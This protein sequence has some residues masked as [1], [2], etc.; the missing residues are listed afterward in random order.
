MNNYQS[1]VEVNIDNLIHNYK[2]LKKISH[3]AKVCA[4]VKANGYGL[5][6]IT[7]ARELQKEGIDYLAVANASEGIALRNSDI[8]L[9]ILVLGYIKDGFI[10]EVLENNLEMTVYN[11][12]QCEKI[13][14]IAKTANK[15][16]N[17]H[18]KIDTG[19]NRI[20]FLSDDINLDDDIKEIKKIK[21]L[22]NIKIKGIYSHLA[23]ADG[24]DLA[25]TKKQYEKFSNINK[26]LE[27]E[28]IYIP[29]KHIS[30][31]AGAIVCGYYEDMIRIGIGM[32]G[33]YPSKFVKEIN[34]VELKPVASLFTTVTNVKYI[35]KGEFVGYN[36]TFQ[37]NRKTKVATL[38][39]GYAD[40]YPIQL[41]NKGYVKIKGQKAKIIGKVCMDQCMVDITDIEDI[42]IGDSVL[43]YGNDEFGELPIYDIAE[44][45]S[46]I[47]YDLICRISMRIPR[48]YT[49]NEQIFN[50]VD[51]LKR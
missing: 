16:A 49:K 23:D 47:V 34:R 18:I 44:I 4:V 2:E 3:P 7:I 15:V 13:N 42:K 36:C 24:E 14:E 32:Y 11:Y 41:S 37:A 50:I 8:D 1:Y 5:G 25:Y 40:G 28:D 46:T 38:A 51:Y 43:L 35:N 30:N 6:S 27:D 10:E 33:Y 12:G 17:I 9:P 48:I 39:I 31:D 45:S 29:I 19:M 20:G 22:S 21:E 26:Y